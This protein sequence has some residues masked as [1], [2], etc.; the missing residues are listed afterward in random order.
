M[1]SETGSAVKANQ[2]FLPVLEN[3]AKA[4]KL[5]TTLGVFERSRFFFNLPG[6]L[7]ESIEAGRYEAALRQYNKGKFMLDSRPGQILPM[8]AGG[9]AS[10]TARQKRI[11]DKVWANVEKVM[12]EM[13]VLLLARLQEPGRSVEEMERAIEYDYSLF[14]RLSFLK[15]Y[16]L[17][18]SWN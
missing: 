15:K 1:C 14:F 4:Q 11:L 5:R 12:A 9:N 17:G 16:Q 3:S 2:V 7:V 13:K 10:S 8:E 6:S 18:F